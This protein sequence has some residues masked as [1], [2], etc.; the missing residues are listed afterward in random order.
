[1]GNATFICPLQPARFVIC[2]TAFRRA[3]PVFAHLGSGDANSFNSS[4][5]FEDRLGG[6]SDTSLF[7]RFASLRR[8]GQRGLVIPIGKLEIRNISLSLNSDGSRR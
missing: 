5:C 3:A 6:R 8:A 1:M 2:G 4:R 7:D